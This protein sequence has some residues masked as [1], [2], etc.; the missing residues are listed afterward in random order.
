MHTETTTYKVLANAVTKH[1]ISLTAFKSC[2]GVSLMTLI[3]FKKSSESLK[4]N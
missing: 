1:L 2:L 3:I 4:M